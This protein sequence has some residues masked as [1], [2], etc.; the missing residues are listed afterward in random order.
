[1]RI[2]V[3]FSGGKDSTASLIWAVNKYGSDNVEAVFCDTGHEAS[4]TYHYID[5]VVRFCGVRLTVLKSDY[6]FE[7]LARKKGRFPAFNMR[8]CTSELKIRPM[9]NWLLDDVK[10]HVLIIQGIRWEES[11][12]RSKMPKSCRFFNLDDKNYTIRRKDARKWIAKW[13]DSVLRPIIDWSAMDVINYIQENGLKPNPLYYKGFKRVGC[14]PCIM[15]TK[16]EI[17]A[18]R[19]SAPERLEWLI[20]LEAELKSGFFSSNLT[21]ERY[22][23][24]NR[25]GTAYPTIQDYLN[26]IETGQI[27]M[28][29][30]DDDSGGSCMSYYHLCE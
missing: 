11:S 24:G 18:F 15:S 27:D 7:S 30:P 9:I 10:E 12:A 5:H 28:F 29:A 22:W 2:I 21:P 26:A 1:M 4:I 8:F 13:D 6:T 19:L 20:K 25:D 23:T 17:E 14:F 16:S 3:S